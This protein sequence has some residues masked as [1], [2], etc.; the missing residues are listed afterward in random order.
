MKPD[1]VIDSGG[2]VHAVWQDDAA[3]FLYTQLDGDQWSPPETTSLNR[4][5]EMP[6]ASEFAGPSQLAIYT[7]PNPL[8]IAGP[9]QHIFAFWITGEGKLLTSQVRN[10]NFKHV[11]A[12]DSGRTIAHEVAS[13]AAAVDAHGG[14]HLAF[15]R[16][17]D[18]PENPPGI[19]YTRSKNNG[20]NWTVAELLYE[21]PYLRRL[22]VGEANLSVATAA[23][24][25]ELGVYI[26]WDLRPRKQV[27]L[28]QSTDGGTSWEQPALVAGPAPDS[29]LAGPFNIV[30]GTNQR[31]VLL[32]WQ[33]GQPDSTCNLIYQ[34]S[35]D[36]GATWSDPQ[37]VTEELVG[38]APSNEFVTR[39]PNSPEGPLYYLTKTQ[40]KIFLTAWNG[41]EWSQPQVQP[42]LSGFE[43]PEIYTEVIY[44]C[45]R[46]SLLGERL[47]I[48]GC[49]QGGGGDIWVT[50]RDL[51]SSPSWFSSPV[52]S[53]PSPVTED[54]L[55]MEAVEL[56]ATSDDLIHA[57][58]SQRRDSV[59]YYT[60]W[61]G[62]L[63]SHITPV[64]KLPDGD[65][66]WPAIAAGPRNELFLIAPNNR[67]TLYFS[68]ATSSTAAT[69]SGWPPPAR[70]ALVHDGKIG[71][72]DVAWD[73]AGTLYVAYS[74]PV[75]EE[76]GI[77]LVLSQDQG[78]TWSEPLQV[79]DGAAAGFDLVGAPSL[80]ASADGLLHVTWKEQS[81][82][83]DGVPQPLSLYYTRSEDGGHT[84]SA[85]DQV[86]G[87]PVTWR[88]IVADNNGNLH[89]LWQ[90]RMA[91]VWD[92]V[93]LD[94]GH[95]W[96]YPQGLP[97]EES[98]ATVTRDLAGRLHLVS[99]GPDALDHWLWEGS[100][101]QSEAPLAWSLSSQPE[102]P[103]ALLAAAINKQGKLMV[104]WA[105]PTGEGDVAQRTLL[106]STR[107][108]K[109]PPEQT[110]IQD[111]P[112]ETP[113]VPTT[114][115]ATSTPEH[116]VTSTASADTPA[117]MESQVQQVETND[118][119][120]PLA[121][122][123]LPVTL[124]L[125]GVLGIAIWRTGQAKDR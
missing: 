103:A 48:V 46:A 27:F 62:E 72:V 79:F 89:L 78:A 91:A 52:W 71:S 20:W 97:G 118:G 37:P 42:I 29:G 113:A 8:F 121:M 95:T 14:L 83:R 116:L 12:W 104:V 69:E 85:A 115:A 40:S 56:V 25:V 111:V 125:L 93:S 22:A 98:L 81:I 106:Y 109:L 87:E 24:K 34:S 35:H 114:S 70:L 55:D 4:L 18:D 75:N 28:A 30:V 66:G 33:N 9:G 120:S 45:Q 15:L 65:A 13:F 123:L 117:P 41:L 58:F 96:Q 86:V 10:Q 2:V 64:L 61:D 21:S 74:I 54:N 11:V 77:Y 50:S 107:A 38:C 73:A 63:W 88:E 76:R 19:Y 5:F 6:A 49:D 124:L 82:Q 36:A 51:G 105:E 1:I 101:W 94:S 100:R 17:A 57:F 68:R 26:A 108:L 60:C 32:V 99:V 44:G 3:N 102:R 59:I 110:A 16:T 53:E 23:A 112:A 92:Q 122:A 39:L 47:Y 7:G 31:S 119:M 84:F 80:L 43:E 67:G 90:N